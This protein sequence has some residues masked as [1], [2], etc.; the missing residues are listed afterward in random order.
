MASSV[1]RFHSNFQGFLDLIIYY[2]QEA[3]EKGI[4]TLR[5]EIFQLAKQFITTQDPNKVIE[6]FTIKTGPHWDLIRKR[7]VDFFLNHANELFHVFSAQ[8]I[9]SFKLL[10]TTKDFLDG[11]DLDSIWNYIHSMIRIS[12]KWIHEQRKPVK[13]IG[14]DGV[15]KKGYTVRYL[16][17]ID[18][19]HH[20]EQWGVNLV[21]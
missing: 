3:G 10:F 16:T 15:E 7:D 18:L 12:M 20:A 1:E 11:D 14:D 8:H 6:T 17:E 5:P 21:F 13:K 2:L 19:H 4:P 9:E